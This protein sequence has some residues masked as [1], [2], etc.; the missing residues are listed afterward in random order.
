MGGDNCAVVNAGLPNI[1]GIGGSV[2]AYNIGGCFS[3][4]TERPAL[5][6]GSAVLNDLIM[7]ASESSPIYGNSTT[8][9]PPSF[10]LFPQIKY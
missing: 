1:T 4:G 8:V 7:D 9:Q 10:S 2:V 6:A 5:G 3:Y